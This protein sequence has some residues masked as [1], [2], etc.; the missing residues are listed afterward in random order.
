VLSPKCRYIS[1]T[2]LGQTDRIYLRTPEEKDLDQI[3]ALWTNPA[4]T[5][6][7]GGPR[8]PQVVLDH[9][10]QVTRDPEAFAQEEAEWWWSI[11]E[12]HSGELVGLCHLIGKEVEGQTEVDVGYFLLP[13][14]WGQGYATE[15]ASV[16]VAYAFC[17]LQLESVVAII[18]PGNNASVSVARR[19][20]MQLEQEVLRSDGVTRRV[21]R[22]GRENRPVTV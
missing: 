6:H 16:I 9:F 4:V 7:I 3:L 14:Y 11:V 10:R 2:M 8:E 1:R 15:A 13:A 17:E 5:R 21:Y 18:D 22:L 12:L 20:G 19:L